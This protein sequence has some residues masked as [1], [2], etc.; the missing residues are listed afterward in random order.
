MV[1]VTACL[2]SLA[3]VVFSTDPT[4]K[5]YQKLER[6]LGSVYVA[7]C[8]YRCIGPVQYPHRFVWF[9][10]PF[11]SILLVRLMAT[12][13]ELC[14]ISQI[15]KALSF[16]ESEIY[17]ITKRKWPHLYTQIVAVSMVVLI[18]VAEAC[19]NYATATQNILF[20]ALEESCW[21]LAFG[22]AFPAFVLLTISA[23]RAATWKKDG[24]HAKRCN[25][26]I[27]ALC[28]SAASFGYTLYMFI[29][30]VPTYIELYQQQQGEGFVYLSFL[31]GLKNAADERVWTRS[32]EDWSY[33]TVW[34]TCYFSLAAWA[35]IALMHAP[36][37]ETSCS[38][39]TD[40]ETDSNEE[41]SDLT[42]SETD[43]NEESLAA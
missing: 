1:D 18:A 4:V 38:E 23:W 26:F 37:L 24:F 33:A 11:S 40:S 7:V 35:S 28:F 8:A 21:G 10:T 30:D 20:N 19:S 2:Y 22:I 15:A 43:S 12:V 13:A 16:C 3:T 32:F 39:L 17:H 5:R 36:R 41:S 42:D 31:Q 6:G 25:T 9:D 29:I 27:F 34:Q 14:F